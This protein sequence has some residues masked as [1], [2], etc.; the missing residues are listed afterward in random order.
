M[1][2]GDELPED[3]GRVLKDLVRRYPVVFTDT[4]AT[5]VRG[6]RKILEGMSESEVTLT[7]LSYIVTAGRI[8]LER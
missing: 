5:Q 8:I 6:H 3:Q 7:I 4:G 2:L 1:K